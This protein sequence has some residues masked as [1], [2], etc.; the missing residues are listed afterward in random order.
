M[1][2]P[3]AEREAVAHLRTAFDMSE[4]W[5]C[6]PNRPTARQLSQSNSLAKGLRHGGVH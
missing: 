1:V 5:A 6:R 3:A 2:T 4:R